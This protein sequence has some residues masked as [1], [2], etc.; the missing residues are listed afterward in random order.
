MTF[1]LLGFYL[2]ALNEAHMQYEQY[3]HWNQVYIC[4]TKVGPGAY[5]MYLCDINYK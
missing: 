2:L 1:Y 4:E 3:P 5:E